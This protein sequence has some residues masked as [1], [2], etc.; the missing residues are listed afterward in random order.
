MFHILGLALGIAV[1]L[2]VGYLV[3]RA[4]FPTLFF[5][6]KENFMVLE[7]KPKNASRS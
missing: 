6:K 2:F 4:Y 3:V 1:L 7:A 5:G